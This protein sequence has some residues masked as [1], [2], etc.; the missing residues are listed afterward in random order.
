METALLSQY[1]RLF[2]CNWLS[3]VQFSRHIQRA[4]TLRE[5]LSSSDELL[6][7]GGL[8]EVQIERVREVSTS[9]NPEIV[10]AD[11]AWTQVAGN[12]IICFEDARYPDLLR[13]VDVAPPVLFVRGNIATLVRPQLAIVGSRNATSYGL[14]NAYW[15]AHEL[16]L[17]GICIT[18]GMARGIDTRAH[19]GALAGG[20]ATIAII[21]T[22]ADVIYPPSNR[23][24]A[25]QIVE[26]GALVSE[27]P[28]GTMPISYNF[29]RRNRIMSGLCLG[30]LVVEAT[31]KSGSLITAKLALEQNRE[32]F[33]IPGLISNPQSSGC[34]QLIADGARLVERP[35]DILQELGMDAPIESPDDLKTTN[36]GSKPV[37]PDGHNKESD[38]LTRLIGY[39]GCELQYL[40]DAS[41][42]EYQT[43]LRRLL[44]LEVAGKIHASGGRYY[45]TQ[46]D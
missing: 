7:Y 32:V 6:Q 2:H 38:R 42:L 43:L 1:L 45:R 33:A 14:R 3:P 46:V 13:Q 15:M 40:L 27:F 10:N 26:T 39:Q 9:A 4:G 20:Q 30:T 23:R 34:H 24:L 35:E 36:A 19:Q 18:S 44:E 41:G 25:E 12:D 21:G 8:T 28:L 22:G 16:S 31:L 37:K 5:F 29:P 17:A 11:L